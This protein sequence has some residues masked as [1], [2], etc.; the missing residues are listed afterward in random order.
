ML[1]VLALVLLAV[2]AGAQEGFPLKG[3]WL[4]TW[5]GNAVHG[6][7]VLVV[8]DWDGQQIS[9]VINPGT[10]DMAISNA[11]LTP[12]GWV[13]HFEADGKDRDGNPVHYVVDG[14]IEN[15]S[16]HNRSVKGTWRSQAGKGTFTMSRQ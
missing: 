8:L 16:F 9:G 6:E 5:E 3:S 12:E 2:S 11:T 4:G 15:L 7:D 1:A 14:A 10:D 13:V